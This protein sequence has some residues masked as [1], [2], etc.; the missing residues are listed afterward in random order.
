MLEVYHLEIIFI[1]EKMAPRHIE[2]DSF[3]H[4]PGCIPCKTHARVTPVDRQVY[5]K[6]E[7]WR[8]PEV[9]RSK[10]LY[11]EICILLRQCAEEYSLGY[12]HAAM[13]TGKLTPRRRSLGLSA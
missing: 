12:I 7:C 5:V 10:G 11:V 8:T 4:L 2:L 1:P 3:V 13:P 6:V 9:H